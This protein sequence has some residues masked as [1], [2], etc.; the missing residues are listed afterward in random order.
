MEKGGHGAESIYGGP[1]EDE[2]THGMVP[3]P[4][5]PLYFP[6]T[7]KPYSAVTLPDIGI[8]HYIGV[9]HRVTYTTPPPPVAGW[10]NFLTNSVSQLRIECSGQVICFDRCCQGGVHPSTCAAHPPECRIRI[11]ANMAHIRQ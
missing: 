4:Q 11:Q 8:P 7:C 5:P 3:P 2:W 9:S 1:F 6:G 10:R